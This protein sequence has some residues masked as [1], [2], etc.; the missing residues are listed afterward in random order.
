MN[1]NGGNLY[2]GI[3]DDGTV[4]GLPFTRFFLFFVYFISL[5]LIAIGCVLKWIS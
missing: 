3:E 5:G 4:R 1:G 2:Y